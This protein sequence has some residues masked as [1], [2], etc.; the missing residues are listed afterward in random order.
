MRTHRASDRH[1]KV[2]V[3]R[4]FFGFLIKKYQSFWA[5]SDT[6]NIWKFSGDLSI[7][8]FPW[9]KLC[10]SELRSSPPLTCGF[11][12]I[13]GFAG[14]VEISVNELVSCLS[15]GDF[16]FFEATNGV[17]FFWNTRTRT[18]LTNQQPTFA[19]LVCAPA[20]DSKR[21][22][23]RRKGFCSERDGSFKF[24]SS[25][26]NEF[27]AKNRELSAFMHGT[28]AFQL[29]C[30]QRSQR[31]MRQEIQVTILGSF[32]EFIFHFQN[33]V[34]WKCANGARNK[35]VKH[36]LNDAEVNAKVPQRLANRKGSSRLP[37]ISRIFAEK[38]IC[39][40][41]VPFKILPIHS[42][43][44]KYA[45]NQPNTTCRKLAKQSGT[46]LLSWVTEVTA[47]FP[48]M[49]Q[50]VSEDQDLCW[51]QNCNEK[52]APDHKI[53]GMIG[54]FKFPPRT[55]EQ[56]ANPDLRAPSCPGAQC[57][58]IGG[59]VGTLFHEFCSSLSSFAAL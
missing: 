15:L 59:Y 19:A 8:N 16:S 24:R 27:S 1:G 50:W 3:L 17:F 36:L 42:H 23:F 39:C 7:S 35:Q 33:F 52:F 14:I 53:S 49:S 11:F 9:W 13:K 28:V 22:S 55:R 30:L 37:I 45:S 12:S 31:I 10:D 20:C 34:Q 32:A 38:E 57:L 43:I 25:L 18:V 48:E 5:S 4:V 41:K 54:Y 40:D 46:A 58:Q 29:P 26:A 44:P 2:S 56:R 6:N 51:R 21:Q 47:V